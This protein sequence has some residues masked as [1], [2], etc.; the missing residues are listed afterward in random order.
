[1]PDEGGVLELILMGNPPSEQ[2]LYFD[3]EAGTYEESTPSQRHYSR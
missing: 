3:V 2:R 1:V